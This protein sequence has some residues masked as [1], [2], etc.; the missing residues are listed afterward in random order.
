MGFFRRSK[1]SDK[2]PKDVEKIF[3]E[4]SKA[5]Q[6]REMVDKAISF[7]NLGQFDKAL[8]ILNAVIKNHPE[9]EPAVP[10]LGTTLMMKGEIDA[11]ERY[12]LGVLNKYRSGNNFAIFEI[13]AN[14]GLLRW[15]HRHDIDGALKYY[16]LALKSPKPDRK[17]GWSLTDENFEIARSNVYRDLGMLHFDSGNISLA[18]QFATMRLNIVKDCYIASKTLGTCI[19]QEDIV[20]P[21]VADMIIRDKEPEALPVAI[22]CFRTC[23]MEK[24]HEP[25]FLFGIGLSISLLSLWATYH[26]KPVNSSLVEEA[27]TYTKRLFDLEK[28]SE[29]AKGLCETFIGLVARV[30]A[31]VV[32][33][34]GT[35]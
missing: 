11:A 28:K 26:N 23:L 20:T 18:K 34:S 5:Q 19:L 6:P 17:E 27:S 35:K 25:L 12:L 31:S 9:Y 3:K 24:P 15:K 16:G 32:Q 8:G 30:T 1:D 7:R 22:R 13:Y 10:I 14:L 29:V 4:I 33:K 21:S 2:L